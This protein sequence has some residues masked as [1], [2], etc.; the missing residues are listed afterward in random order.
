MKSLNFK[1]DLS[2][3]ALMIAPSAL[4]FNISR[5]F[6]QVKDMSLQHALGTVVRSIG[7]YSC[8]YPC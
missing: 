3:T 7:E 5:K 1:F 2:L 8:A 4:L 6:M